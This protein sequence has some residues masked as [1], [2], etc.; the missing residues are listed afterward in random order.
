M[1]PAR[2]DQ[3]VGRVEAAG[4]ADDDLGLADR[5]QP[6]LQPATWMLYAS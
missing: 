6:L 4:D 2:D 5:A 3:R 1:R